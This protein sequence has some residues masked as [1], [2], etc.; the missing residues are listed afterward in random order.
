MVSDKNIL[1]LNWQAPFS[2]VNRDEAPD[3]SDSV[4]AY[5]LLGSAGCPPHPPV[6]AMPLRFSS[7][8]RGIHRWAIINHRRINFAIYTS[9][10]DQRPSST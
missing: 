1:P 2:G 4:T 6:T 7:L 3:G 10:R 5:R 9:K 8:E